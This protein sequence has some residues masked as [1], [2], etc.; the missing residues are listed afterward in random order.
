MMDEQNKDFVP[1]TELPEG[2]E[3]VTET[4][5]E[6]VYT[7]TV[8]EDASVILE[9]THLETKKKSNF[10]SLILMLIFSV[11]NIPSMLF[12]NTYFF[13]SLASTQMITSYSFQMVETAD[14]LKYLV[15]ENNN[16]ILRDTTA[17][18]MLAAIAVAVIA[19]F[20]VLILL[21]KKTI[22]TLYIAF[23]LFIVDTVLLLL[24]TPL[25]DGILNLAFHAWI[26]YSF[27]V[28]IRAQNKLRRI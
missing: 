18:L 23:G 16:P 28:V 17:V 22:I 6:Q 10:F 4:Q 7:G 24:L 26:L 12:A 15:D 20:L 3:V 11:I 8:V 2:S 5:E 13:F 25:A 27:V 9:R 1:Q 21:S 14:G 19:V